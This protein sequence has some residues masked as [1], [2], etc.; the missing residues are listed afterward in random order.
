MT[1]GPRADIDVIIYICP[2]LLHPRVDP[3]SYAVPES[4]TLRIEK[5]VVTLGINNTEFYVLSVEMNHCD[6]NVIVISRVIDSKG[7]R[8]AIYLEYFS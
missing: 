8:R 6:A 5:C 3:W 7:P 4:K 1:E 2:V